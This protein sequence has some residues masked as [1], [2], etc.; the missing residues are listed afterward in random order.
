MTPLTSPHQQEASTR[1]APPCPNCKDEAGGALAGWKCSMCGQLVSAGVP[2]AFGPSVTLT[3]EDAHFLA[4][5]LR[6]LCA[7]Q[8]YELPKF[9]ADDASL[10]NIAGSV[11]GALLTNAAPG[12]AAPHCRVQQVEM[13]EAQ[14]K[15]LTVS[16]DVSIPGPRT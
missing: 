4:V 11:I 13:T 6:R 9:A 7:H 12:V 1:G 2:E 5:R 3:G 16:R 15:L 14:R 8:G 10:I